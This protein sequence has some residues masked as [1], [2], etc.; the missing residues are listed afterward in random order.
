MGITLSD[1]ERRY[2]AL[3]DEATGATARDCVI[4]EAEDR[5]VF[6]VAAGEMRTAIGPDGRTVKRVEDRLGSDV[7]LVEDADRPEAFVANALAPAAIL[8]VA[9]EGDG[10]TVA[11]VEVAAGDEGAA[12]GRGGRNIELARRLAKRHF[13]IDDIELA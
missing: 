6:V 2:I 9:I 7:R 5:V 4:D 13:D 12:I 10:T 1:R 8:G 11:R 3:F